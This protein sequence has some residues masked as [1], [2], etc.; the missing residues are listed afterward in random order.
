M[1]AQSVSDGT[2]LMRKPEDT[3]PFPELAKIKMKLSDSKIRLLSSQSDSKATYG[4]SDEKKYLMD[5]LL[6]ALCHDKI[7]PDMLSF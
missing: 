4:V 6:N 3:V 7:T 2:I 1:A 5:L